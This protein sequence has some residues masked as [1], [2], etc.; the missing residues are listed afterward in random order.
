MPRFRWTRYFK[1]KDGSPTSFATG[2]FPA[3]VDLSNPDIP[4]ETVKRIY[5][6]GV[7]CLEPTETGIN[8]FYPHLKKKKKGPGK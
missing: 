3:G 8:K 4:L 1:L 6:S 5:E 2:K 7:P